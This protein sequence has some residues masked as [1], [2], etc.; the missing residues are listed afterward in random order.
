MPQTDWRPLHSKM[1]S[2]KKNQDAVAHAA[3]A[4]GYPCLREK[5]V[6]VVESFVGVLPTG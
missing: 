1:T 2:E 4:L 5:Q 3:Q 6:G